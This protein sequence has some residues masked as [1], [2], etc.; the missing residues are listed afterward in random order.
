MSFSTADEPPADIIA[1]VSGSGSISRPN[2]FEGTFL[3]SVDGIPV[4]VSIAVIHGT[5]Y[6]KVPLSQSYVK[7][8]ASQYGFPDPV[9][10]FSSSVGFP[11]LL[12]AT[13]NL[14]YGGIVVNGS[15]SDWAISGSIPD[16]LLSNLFDTPYVK[17]YIHIT[18]DI[19]T[20]TKT[21]S[22][23]TVIAPFFTSSTNSSFT[24]TIDKYNEVVHMPS[25]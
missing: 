3:V 7:G 13:K 20:S 11:S 15:T 16:T 17:N 1:T 18:Y 6:I 12:M 22:S 10:L 25:V 5:S 23:I 9:S 8:S 2:S 4:N 14:S 24:I 21:L 19:S